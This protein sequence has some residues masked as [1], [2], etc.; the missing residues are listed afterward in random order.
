MICYNQLKCTITRIYDHLEICKITLLLLFDPDR[1][2]ID[3][4]SDCDTKSHGD[5]HRIICQYVRSCVTYICQ[6]N[7][8]DQG[9]HYLA[10]KA[11]LLKVLSSAKVR[12]ACRTLAAFPLVRLCGRQL[13]ALR[14]YKLQ[15]LFGLQD[16]PFLECFNFKI[17]RPIKFNYR[18][19]KYHMYNAK[20]LMDKS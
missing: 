9:R 5:L 7:K 2:H 10:F 17:F 18:L 16:Y 8:H 11:L 6:H 15:S 4:L 20:G 1:S 13:L 19:Y 14:M 3:L 12:P